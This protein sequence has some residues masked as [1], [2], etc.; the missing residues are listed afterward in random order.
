MK[1]TLT[2]KL[3]LCIDLDGTLLR[4]DVLS[5]ALLIYIRRYPWKIFNLLLWFLKGRA[6]LKKRIADIIDLDFSSLPVNQKM[7]DLIHQ[8]KKEGYRILLVTAAPERYG[9]A[10]AAHFG[11]FDDVMTSRE[12][13]NLRSRQKAEALSQKFGQGQFIYAGNSVHDLPVWEQAGE[14][15]AINTP[16]SVLK[17]ALT[18]NKPYLFLKEGLLNLIEKFQMILKFKPAYKSELILNGA[19][20]IILMF[21]WIDKNDFVYLKFLKT[22]L[23]G[24]IYLSFKIFSYLLLLVKKR[25][26]HLKIND[27][28]PCNNLLEALISGA[29]PLGSAIRFA[30]TFLALSLISGFILLKSNV[31]GH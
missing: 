20:I 24:N 6:Y 15:I 3:P 14:I 21:I 18:F 2:P 30:L 26:N 7:I 8:Y 5:E 23:I 27:S 11:F 17:K 29:F 12:N 19:I 22:F 16:S 13:H 4:T 31:M 10:A 28:L 25:K 1:L 9:F